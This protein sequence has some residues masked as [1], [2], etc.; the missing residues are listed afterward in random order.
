MNIAALRERIRVAEFQEHEQGSLR[1]WLSQQLLQL[2]PAI[3]PGDDPLDT[4][5]R[6]AEG[7]IAEVPDTLE[8]AQAVADSANMRAQLLPVLKVAEAFF[9]QPPDLPADHQ[10]MLALLDEA[11]LVHRLVEEVNDRYIAHGGEPLLPLD[12]TRANVIVHQLLGDTFANQLDLAVNTAVEGLAPESLF[13]S[14]TFDDFRQII[15]QRGRIALWQD[16]PCLSR[17]L[18]VEIRLRETN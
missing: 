13:S 7:Y 3:T 11:Y 6:L 9:L 4:L 15:A 5:Q 2:H 18:G 12:T 16:W 8:A 14:Q 10:G 17:Q 1:A